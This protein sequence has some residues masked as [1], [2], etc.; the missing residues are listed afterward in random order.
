MDS[1]GSG[2]GSAASA[3]LA[4][5]AGEIPRLSGSLSI[6]SPKPNSGGTFQP[7]ALIH[8]TGEVCRHEDHRCASADHRRPRAGAPPCLISTPISQTPLRTASAATAIAAASRPGAV[9][10][11]ISI[12]RRGDLA[13]AELMALTWSISAASHHDLHGAIAECRGHLDH[14]CRRDERTR[15]ARCMNLELKTAKPHELRRASQLPGRI[16]RSM[17]DQPAT[18]ETRSSD[19]RPRANGKHERVVL[20][21]VSCAIRQAGK[22]AAGQAVAREPEVKLYDLRSKLRASTKRES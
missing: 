9:A 5:C 2:V 1:V 14:H 13:I 6:V 3:G 19:S 12:N 10:A 17:L 7:C 21:P 18:R 20:N 22:A 11:P 16:D 4:A 15:W 8:S